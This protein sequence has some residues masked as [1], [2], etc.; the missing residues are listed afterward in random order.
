MNRL[1]DAEVFGQH[2]ATEII[3]KQL[4][5]HLTND[6]PAKPLV[7]SFHGWTGNGKNHVAY[8]IAKSLYRNGIHSHLYHHFMATVHFPH[9]DQAAKY[10]DQIRNWV[11]GNVSLCAR[12]LFV[13]DE[14][15]KMPNGV[16]DGI[17]AFLDYIEAVDKVDYR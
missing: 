12:S 11:R 16:L 14:V 17:R 7:M 13:F 3:S 9:Q 15:D 6:F 10:Q 8:L 1:L 5:A 4:K 2:I